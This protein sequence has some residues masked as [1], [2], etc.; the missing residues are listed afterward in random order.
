M[1]YRS[2]LSGRVKKQHMETLAAYREGQLRPHPELRTLFLEMTCRCNEHCRHCGSGCGD[3]TE[4]NPLTAAEIHDL[5][6]TVR[7]DFTK[8]PH[9]AVTG[10]E[11]LLRRDFF[12][13]MEDAAGLGFSWGMTSNGTLIDGETAHHLATAGMRT[14]SISVDGLREYHDW[15]RQSP[16]AFDRTMAGIRALVEEPGLDHVQITTV[17]THRNYASLADVYELVRATG[18]KSWRVINMEPIGRARQ[19]QELLLTKEEYRGL[20]HFIREHRYPKDGPEVLYGCS[21]YLGVK[22]EREVRPWYFLCN[23][24]VYTASVCYNGEVTACLDIERRPEIMQGN[25]RT[26]RFS[27]LWKNGFSIYRTDWRKTGPCATCPDY[28]FCAG[29]SF[30]TWD[31]DNMRPNLCMKGILF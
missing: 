11:P 23:A 1:Q 27:N 22:Q 26:E 16:G 10:G 7:E 12:A 9:L 2:G 31:F 3:F 30:H 15:F 20:F 18:V 28:R 6:V 21:H 14:I 24:G 8:L 4:E 19:Q 5:L 25:I 17:V 29:D 13:I